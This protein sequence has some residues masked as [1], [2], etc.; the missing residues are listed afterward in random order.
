MRIEKIIGDRIR[1]GRERLGITQAELG[2]RLA[3]LL[4]RSLSRQAISNTEAGNRSFTAVDLVAI[5]HALEWPDASWFLSAVGSE[6]IE[7]PSGQTLPPREEVQW[8]DVTPFVFVSAIDALTRIRAAAVEI[9]AAA[10]R[11]RADTDFADTCLGSVAAAFAAAEEPPAAG[12]Q[13]YSPP[14][15]RRPA[16]DAPNGAAQDA[17]QN[18][19]EEEPG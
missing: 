15:P 4:G 9:E 17:G 16:H 13:P 2:E 7:L 14:G 11:I 1:Q 12:P 18:A 19:Q 5:A 10:Q 6:P 8:P 3:P